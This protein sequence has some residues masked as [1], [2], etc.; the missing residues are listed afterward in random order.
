MLSIS[1]LGRRFAALTS[2]AALMALA[3]CSD[4]A[5]VAVDPV[6]PDNP[7]I[8]AQYRSAA[9]IMDVSAV[10]KTVRISAPAT[11]I[12]GP[13]SAAKLNL[14]VNPDRQYSL[15]GGDVIDISTSNFAASA[16]GAFIPGKVRITFDMT[17][18]N[19]LDGI[20]LITPTFPTPPAGVTGLQAFP[21]EISVTTTSGGVTSGGNEVVVTSPR[22]GEVVPSTNWDGDF[23]NFFNDAACAVT[24]NDCFRYESFGQ[25]E[26]LGSSTTQQ[27]GFDI[28]PTVGDFRVRIIL[29]ADLENG[30]APAPGSVT[31]TVTSPQIGAITGATVNVSG[32]FSGTTAAG[33]A[34]TVAG[35]ATGS[36]TV[37]VTNLPS[38]CVA[39][40][41]QAI[42]VA[43]G[44][45]TTADFVV[46]CTVPTGTIAGTVTSSLGGGLSGVIV[47]ATPTGGAAVT[48]TTS[49]TGTYSI[50]NVPA[51]SAT[52]EL[53][54]SNLPSN[55][56]NPGPI[57]YSGF[58]TAGLSGQDIVVTCTTPP[59]T[60]P[61]T[62][63]YGPITTV[64]GTRRVQV[65]VRWNVGTI[66]A[67]GLSGSI[68][69]DG[70]ALTFLSRQFTSTFDT[71]AQAVAN[72]GTASAALNFA[73]GAVS[74]SFETGDFQVVA[75]TF[76]IANGFS[77][78]LNP[79]LTISEA[80][81]NGVAT[82]ITSS[83]V[84]T[85][86]PPL[87]IP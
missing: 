64:G 29:A 7:A 35:V 62:F 52:G 46:T 19:R 76:T 14:G 59:A 74:P 83:V 25:I 75:F 17:I 50:A 36:R 9:F 15:L 3:A 23:H 65:I 71:G 84:V 4:S 80:L 24:S 45:A 48:G 55:C 86:L 79:T 6:L 85:A 67:V 70:T 41:S 47:S 66:E 10:R 8:P 51:L 57:A 54:L 53:S 82:P 18:N 21:F 39:P 61:V 68:G 63:E 43:S 28:D 5:P 38:G 13:V 44:A 58:T 77:G 20:R 87:I 12:A 73:Y 56:T 34:Y 81:Q 33:G 37:S 22:F 30:V 11:G 32:G 16:V 60:Y 2:A 1:T 31:G 27:V 40:A 78:T 26:P 49:G 42:T 69:F 72:P